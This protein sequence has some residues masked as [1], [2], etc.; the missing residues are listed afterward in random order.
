MTPVLK[1]AEEA[2]KNGGQLPEVIDIFLEKAPVSLLALA[3]YNQRWDLRL[4]SVPLYVREAYEK[5]IAM[6]L[7]AL[8][9]LL[10]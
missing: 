6:L 4:S 10:K 5:E 1:A 3:L 2:L 8:K 7:T 9:A